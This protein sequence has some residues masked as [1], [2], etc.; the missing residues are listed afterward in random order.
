[1][2]SLPQRFG[3]LSLSEVSP[4]PFLTYPTSHNI[5]VHRTDKIFRGLRLRETRR[6]PLLCEIWG[7]LY[8]PTQAES[9][10]IERDN[11][12]YDVLLCLDHKRKEGRPTQR[13]RRDDMGILNKPW[14]FRRKGLFQGA[15]LQSVFVVELPDSCL[16]FVHHAS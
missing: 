13:Y 10:V 7:G 15:L 11:R 6:L 12:M 2:L 9:I 8:D 4:H 14:I 16:C 3:R 5:S 1:M